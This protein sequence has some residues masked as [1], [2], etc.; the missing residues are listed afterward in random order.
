MSVQ[1]NKSRKLLYFAFM[2][3]VV[4][5]AAYLIDKTGNKK[6]EE[7]RQE[8]LKVGVHSE[9]F[10]RSVDTLLQ[11]YFAQKDAFVEWDTV[12]VKQSLGALLAALDRFPVEELRKDSMAVYETVKQQIADIRANAESIAMQTNITEM[13]QDFRMVSENLYPLLKTIRY[14]G[15]TL[16]W[17]NCP[18]AFG[19]DKGASWISNSEEIVNPYLGKF[20]PTYKSGMLHCGEVLD[21]IR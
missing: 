11:A 21:S 15:S 14:N 10:N 20:D 2:A 18:M 5:V 9:G 1:S 8:A 6:T 7:P 4:L 3:L 19:D 17:Q 13:R 12:K 16:Y